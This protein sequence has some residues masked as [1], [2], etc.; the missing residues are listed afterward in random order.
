MDADTKKL[1]LNQ[2]KEL[3]KFQTDSSSSIIK[4]L[5]KSHNQKAPKIYTKGPNRIITQKK[6]KKISGFVIILYKNSTI[7]IGEMSNNQKNGHGI[8]TFPKTDIY[9]IGNY[10][11]NKKH[12]NGR[13]L[14]ISDDSEIYNGNWENDEKHG[15]GFFKTEKGEYTGEFLNDDMEGK[16]KMV[17]ENGD[18]FEGTFK[19]GVREG[20]GILK[21][22]CGDVYEGYFKDG[23]MHGDG[24]YVW[25][26]GICFHGSFWENNVTHKGVLEFKD[27]KV[28]DFQRDIKYD[29]NVN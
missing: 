9:Y 20:F 10:F 3:E 25:K 11:N 17:F 29:L 4:K 2:T 22:G 14:K 21:F 15:K 13:V 7:Y 24:V 16:G 28:L 12:G 26:N 5:F 19:A 8:R 6:D 1:I 23:L 27:F 18:F